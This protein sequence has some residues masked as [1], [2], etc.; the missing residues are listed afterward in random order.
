MRA[1]WAHGSKL[2][3]KKLFDQ[4]QKIVKNY[5]QIFTSNLELT[6]QEDWLGQLRDIIGQFT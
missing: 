1:R 6:G 2:N 3:S 5:P 4:W